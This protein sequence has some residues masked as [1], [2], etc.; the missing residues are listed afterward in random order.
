MAE[1]NTEKD[2]GALDLSALGSFDFTPAWAKGRPD[3]TAK[4]ARFE[5]R[6]SDAPR[7][8]DARGPR[9]RG[10]PRFGGGANGPRRDDR[11][12]FSG[13]PRRD[14]DDRGPRSEGGR[15]PFRK[16]PGGDRRDRPPREFVKPLD[17]EVRILPGQK[18]LGEFIRK[19]QGQPYMAYPLKQLAYFFLEHLDACV[20]RIAPKK[21]VPE[22]ADIQF[23]QCKACGFVA[24]SQEELA[25]H[26]M[27]A[28]LSDYYESEEIECEPPKGSFSCVA[29]C[30]LS[31]ELLGPPNLH[32]YDARIRE[33]IRTRFPHMDEQAYRARIEMVRDADTV[34]AWRQ[35]ATKKTVYRR[36]VDAAEAA[37]AA[38]AA[39]GEAPAEAPVV[40]A[41][42][43][44]A[45]EM[46]FRRQI[47]PALMTTP[48]AVDMSAEM[49]LKSS[50]RGLVF[51]CR[52]A[53]Q[54][55]K[56]FPASLFYALRGAFHHRKLQFFRAND[57]RGPEFVTSVKP[58]A[59]DTAHA[60]PELVE[61]VKYVEEHPDLAPGAVVSALA[62]GDA[63]KVN[64]TKAHIRWLL[65]KGHLVCYANGGLVVPAEHPR[66][67][68]A[69]NRKPQPAAEKP[70]EAP[71][72][73]AEA[74]AAEVPAAEAPAAEAPAG[75][76]PA[77]EPPAAEPAPEV[78]AAE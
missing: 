32:G 1:D 56:R 20:L 37:A 51:A 10:R 69:G 7:G 15:P 45:A 53:L 22:A 18:Q 38:P 34:E 73:V 8:G 30:G 27:S 42:E 59:L 60:I 28:H 23:H 31:G 40:A 75:E 48:K 26:V 54:R 21:G 49:A 2:S 33:M 66:W 52:D 61:L 4:F 39:E 78:P 3:D 74:P 58:S 14:R 50:N 65:E 44:E 13:A 9:D 16:G 71:A 76:A 64:T 25:A 55:E 43:R 29:K 46:E 63:E 77:A 36:K 62:G 35:S 68:P 57:P 12:G 17:V 5:E 41:V 72:P 70:A 67:R 47:A 24:F 19:I 11:G 6:A